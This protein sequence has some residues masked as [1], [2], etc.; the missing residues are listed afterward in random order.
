[1]WGAGNILL[2]GAGNDLIQGRGADDIIDGDKY[3]NVR[4]SVRNAAGTEIGSTTV[5]KAGQSPMTQQYLKDANGAPT[6][7]TLQQAVFAGTV[8]P[9]NIVAVK[10]IVSKNAAPDCGAVGGVNCDTALFSGARADYTI[11]TV[12][13]H[14]EVSQTGDLAADQK[15]SDGVD[16]LRNIERLRFSDA[17]VTV[18]TP[19]APTNVTATA[20]N[21]LASVT[22]TPPS[23]TIDSYE[24]VT[25]RDGVVVAALSATGISRLATGR[26]VTNLVP[27]AN[28]TF[29]VRAVNQFGNGPFGVSN[30]IT[31]KGAPA[32][33][34]GV[35]AVARDSSVDLSWTPGSNNGDP[36]T[37]YQVQVRT[38]TTVLATR[39]VTGAVSS[40]TIDG[41]TNGTLYNFR[42]RAV[43]SV[44]VSGFSV[45]S[46]QVRPATVPGPARVGTPTLGNVGG[47][48]TA[49]A[50]WDA[51]LS[52]GG[53]AVTGYRITP[54][55]V[56]GSGNETG[57]LATVN[58]GSTARAL[59][60]TLP[61]GSYRFEV[62]A[63]NAIGNGP[64]ALSTVFQPR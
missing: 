56:D 15:V 3:L 62:I 5:N 1:V 11:S 60:F 20:G 7:P 44:G 52:N 26:T 33:P 30:E 64:A 46:N 28:Y 40:A 54:V 25:K 18:S 50:N 12:G 34:T 53:S 63:F 55:Q 38:G 21:R 41:L 36:I 6:G 14:I 22:W 19:A 48:L 51:P 29:E 31:A 27:G 43:N 23:G 9:G 47:A 10:E 35:V 57:R 24:F 4:L 59:G 58:R 13:D 37:G 8:N 17:T 61:A 2:G 49:V 32:A 45:P 42:L 39:N 16:T